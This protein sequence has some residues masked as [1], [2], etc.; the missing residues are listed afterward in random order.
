MQF[1]LVVL[2]YPFRHFLLFIS[3]RGQVRLLLAEG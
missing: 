3:S 2:I 1:S